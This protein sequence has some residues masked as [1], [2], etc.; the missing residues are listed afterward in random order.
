MSVHTLHCSPLSVPGHW[1]PHALFT[2][3]VPSP[4]P[5]LLKVSIAPDALIRC[6]VCEVFFGSFLEMTPFF[7][8]FFLIPFLCSWRRQL[9]Y[10]SEY[11]FWVICLCWNWGSSSESGS[12]GCR[13]GG[14]NVHSR[15]GEIYGFEGICLG[16]RI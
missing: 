9:S 11:E 2:R 14:E 6:L 15:T 13:A 3:D 8:F 4:P 5:H 12:R 10:W 7:F 16:F 1:V